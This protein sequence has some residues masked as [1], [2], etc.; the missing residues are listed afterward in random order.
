MSREIIVI[1]GIAQPGPAAKGER[2]PPSA[3]CGACAQGARDSAC[4][5]HEI[6]GI[7]Q[8]ADRASGGP[9]SAS[10]WPG[11]RRPSS[12]PFIESETARLSGLIRE[13]NLRAA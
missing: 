5:N 3:G 10:S 1:W 7:L 8:A 9:R 11:A 2:G 12:Q 13:L 4:V 6:T